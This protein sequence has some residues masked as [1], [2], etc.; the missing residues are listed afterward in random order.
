M[1]LVD[2]HPVNVVHMCTVRRGAEE[3]TQAFHRH[4]GGSFGRAREGAR[5]EEEE[6]RRGSKRKENETFRL[7]AV[8]L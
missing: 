4:C 5:L 1:E 7:S 6:E 2:G 3:S 8:L